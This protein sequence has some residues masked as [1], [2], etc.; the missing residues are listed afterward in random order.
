MRIAVISDIHGNL[1]ALRAV[2]DDFSRRDVS[3]VL[4]L[5]DTLSGP[6]L[7]LETARFVMATDWVHLA[8][9]HER[10][11][12]TQRAGERNASDEHTHSQLTPAEF[13]WMASLEPCRAIAPAVFACHGTAVND[14]DY[15]LETVQDCHVR[16]ATL[17]EI[18]ERLGDVTAELVLCGHSHTPRVM[19]SN[20]GQLIVNPGSVG[21]QAF[22]AR[23]PRPHVMQTGSPDA[24]YAIVELVSGSWIPQLVAVPYDYLSMV[25]LAQARSRDDWARALLTG[26]AISE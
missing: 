6:L 15:L 23:R 12:L 9:N 17:N 11:V 8:G 2:V 25:A 22:D 20:R 13:A 4:N 19:R 5:G 21:L 1:P 7:P 10:Q 16:A 24:R 18:E 3:M 26:R 14:L